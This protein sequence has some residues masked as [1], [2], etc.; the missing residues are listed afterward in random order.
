MTRPKTSRGKVVRKAMNSKIT[1]RVQTSNAM[2]LYPIPAMSLPSVDGTHI[3]YFAY[4]W[5]DWSD[6]C[7]CDEFVRTE[8]GVTLSS[9]TG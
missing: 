2:R 3:R 4:I 9:R 6:R 1:T 5:I 8:V 7:E